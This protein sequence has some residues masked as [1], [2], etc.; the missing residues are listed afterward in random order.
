[1][2]KVTRTVGELIKMLEQ[3]P[4]Q[5][6]VWLKDGDLP[7]LYHIRCGQDAGAVFI[8]PYGTAVMAESQQPNPEIGD[9]ELWDAD[10]NCEHNIVA[11]PGGGVRCTKCAGWYCL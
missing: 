8:W 6:E 9:Q 3:F 5:A 2:N 1:M 7:E 11:A 4:A 10:P